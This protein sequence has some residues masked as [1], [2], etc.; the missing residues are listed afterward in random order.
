MSRLRT[1]YR[2]IVGR[3][4]SCGCGLKWRDEYREGW[5]ACWG[6]FDAGMRERERKEAQRPTV[7][8]FN[9]DGSEWRGWA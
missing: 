7:R 4:I 1:W 3:C 5:L 2:R 6:C 8:Y 9:A